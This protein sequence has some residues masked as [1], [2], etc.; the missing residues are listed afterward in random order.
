MS[1]STI[2]VAA[3]LGETLGEDEAGVVDAQQVLHRECGR[4]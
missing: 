2:G 3:P 4:R 1:S